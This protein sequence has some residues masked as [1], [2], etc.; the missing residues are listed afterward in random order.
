MVLNKNKGQQI[1]LRIAPTLCTVFAKF[2]TFV[3]SSYH[4]PAQCSVTTA[5]FQLNRIAEKE[6]ARKWIKKGAGLSSGDAGSG[7]GANNT[8][9]TAGTY[10]L[11]SNG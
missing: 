6:I 9:Y 11:G 5:T 8:L 2:S 4:E 3:R 7:S 10:R 1:S